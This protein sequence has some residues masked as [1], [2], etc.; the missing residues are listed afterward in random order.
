MSTTEAA[1]LAKDAGVG[2]LIL[3]HLIPNLPNNKEME[4]AFMAGMAAIFGG[5]ISLAR[6]TQRITVERQ[7]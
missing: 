5:P 2:R 6:D 7:N 4:D 1:R 3:S